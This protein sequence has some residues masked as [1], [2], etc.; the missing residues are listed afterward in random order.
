MAQQQRNV[1]SFSSASVVKHG[2]AIVSDVNGTFVAGET[3][4]GGTSGVTDVLQSDVVGFKA[5]HL[6]NLHK[7]NKL[8]WQVHQLILLILH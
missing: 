5:Q 6:L 8:V 3:I 2:L 1:T 7:L 4:T